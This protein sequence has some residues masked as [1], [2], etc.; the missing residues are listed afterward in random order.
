MIRGGQGRNAQEMRA[1]A[2]WVGSAILLAFAIVLV[3]ILLATA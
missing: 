2:L 1:A 3:T